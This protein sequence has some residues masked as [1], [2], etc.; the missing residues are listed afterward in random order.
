M[1]EDDLEETDDKV[2]IEGNLSPKKIDR[3]KGNKD[4]QKK[5]HKGDKDIKEYRRMLGMQHSITNTSRKICIFMES[6]IVRT[7]IRDE[8]QQI[9]IRLEN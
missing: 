3:L 7:I 9:T 6:N 4:I 8:E 5:K 1:D 2:G